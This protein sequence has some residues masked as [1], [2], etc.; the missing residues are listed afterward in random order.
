MKL[1]G[2]HK[3]KPERQC[4]RSKCIQLGV[5]G[6]GVVAYNLRHARTQLTY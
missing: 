2:K 6:K 1:F 5:A 3:S 4:T